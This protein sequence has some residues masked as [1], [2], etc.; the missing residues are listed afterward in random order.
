[1][2]TFSLEIITQEKLLL[3]EEVE[4]LYV[5]TADGD[6]TILPHHVPYVSILKPAEIIITRNGVEEPIACTGGILEVT[7]NKVVVLA[8]TAVRSEEIDEAETLKA[9]EGAEK[10]MAEKLEE[11]ENAEAEAALEKALLH[12]RILK[13]R[14]H[15]T[16]IHS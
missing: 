1:M 10:L 12:L 16:S 3:K 2:A 6:I 7:P 13:K 15:H 4:S 14:K 9:K 8:D 11:R 5:T